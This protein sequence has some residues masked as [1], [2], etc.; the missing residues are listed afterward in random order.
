MLSKVLHRRVTRLE[1]GPKMF[2]VSKNFG[3]GEVSAG[4]V[5]KG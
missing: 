5:E 1:G 4:P 2:C 3:E